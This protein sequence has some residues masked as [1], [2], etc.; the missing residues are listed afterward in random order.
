MAV[1]PQ[2]APR[3]R[4]RRALSSVPLRFMRRLLEANDPAGFSSIPAEE[5]TDEELEVYEAIQ[6]HYQ[7]HRVFPLPETLAENGIT[8]PEA[9]EP[10]SYYRDQF[11]NSVRVRRAA[12]LV[13]EIQGALQS[14]NGAAAEALLHSYR[15]ATANPELS[16][17][18]LGDR[19]DQFEERLDPASSLMVRCPTG[20]PAV[21]DVLGGTKRGGVVFIAG[22]PG[23][24]KTFTAIAAAMNLAEDGEQVLF[25]S[26]EMPSEEIEDRMLFML[27]DMDPGINVR[28]FS[29]THTRAVIRERRASIPESVARN[30]VFPNH[31]A[32]RTTADIE[33]AIRLRRPTVCVLDGSYFIRAVEV[34]KTADEREKMAAL[35]RELRE[36]ALATR[37]TIIMT[38]QQNRTKSFG[39]EGLYGTDVASQD[40]SLVLMIKKVIGHPT[41]RE[42]F[43]AKNR[44]GADEFSIGMA[45]GFKPTTVGEGIDLPTDI[46]REDTP[47][48]Q[49]AR[50]R[51][52]DSRGSPGTSEGRDRHVRDAVSA[53]DARRTNQA[54]MG[55][56]PAATAAIPG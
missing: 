36:I 19:V 50:R 42:V 13:T 43:V 55:G 4:V 28:R 31:D 54:G 21:D 5:L 15:E 12:E 26:K 25:I 8:L 48:A 39:T 47:F 9:T 32:I 33:A 20:I 35:I 29:T 10:L 1:A 37:T 22:R 27:T 7:R 56:R 17:V 14:N 53:T 30:V 44:H 6:R 51:R 18:S 34:S 24:G 49:G 2:P 16:F 38:W 23:S 45:Y 46:Q 11:Y 52:G 41:I 3:R 40:A